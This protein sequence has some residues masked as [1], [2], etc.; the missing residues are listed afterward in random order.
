MFNQVSC[1]PY[2]QK[3]NIEDIRNVLFKESQYYWIIMFGIL[4]SINLFQDETFDFRPKCVIEYFIKMVHSK[5]L[6]LRLAA[7]LLKSIK[8]RL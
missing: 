2:K 5:L 6:I 8:M 4:K 7:V 1:L 3:C